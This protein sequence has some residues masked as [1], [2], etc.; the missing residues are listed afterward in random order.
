MRM[1]SNLDGCKV[2]RDVDTVWES[3]L[4]VV[5]EVEVGASGRYVGGSEY[6]FTDA[7]FN[8]RSRCCFGYLTN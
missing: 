4:M 5:D 3:V 7:F 1:T 6:W 2:A 8:C